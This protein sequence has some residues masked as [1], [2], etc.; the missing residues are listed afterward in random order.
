MRDHLSVLDPPGIGRSPDFPPWSCLPVRRGRPGTY[1]PVTPVECG[2]RPQRLAV[3]RARIVRHLRSLPRYETIRSVLCHQAGENLRSARQRS[4]TVGGVLEFTPFGMSPARQ[5][6]LDR[7]LQTANALAI[8][9]W[10]RHHDARG[11]IIRSIGICRPMQPRLRPPPG[12]K[13]EKSECGE[14][15]A[16]SQGEGVIR[17]A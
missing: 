5:R 12:T 3:N 16:R 4:R 2:I 11:N 6:P 1:S 15:E 10:F 8:W 13:P 17:G 14:K 7:T 9:R